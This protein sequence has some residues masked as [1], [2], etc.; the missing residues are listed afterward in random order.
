MAKDDLSIDAFGASFKGFLDKVTA[1]GPAEEP[2]LLCRFREHFGQA[3]TTLPVI[4]EKFPW[5]DR[6]NL[7]IAL[8]LYLGADG[9]A[10]DLVGI[11]GGQAAFTGVHIADL[12]ASHPMMQR[13]GAPGPGPVQYLNVALA[14]EQWLACVQCGVYFLRDGAE[15]LA[16]LVGGG[17]EMGFAG[18]EVRVEVMA[19]ERERGER[20]LAAIRTLMRQKNVYRGQVISLSMSPDRT[21]AVSFHALPQVA[22]DAIILPAGVLER[23]ERS[24]IRF[25]GHRDKLRAAGRH[26]KRGILLHG[27]PGTGKTLT[28]MHLAS[29]MPDRTVLIL[30]GRGQGLLEA[31]CSMARWLA[32][33]TVILEDVDLVAE[34]RTRRGADCNLPLLFEVMNEMD[35]LG[36]DADVLFLLTTNRPDILEPALASRPG[37]VDQ[38]I[39]IP[40]PDEVCRRRLL[41]FYGQGLRMQL[42][43]I[44]AVVNRTQGVSAAFVR[45]LLRKAALFAADEPGDIAVTDRH[46]EEAMRE[47][48]I[49]GGQLTRSLLGANKPQA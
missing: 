28:A 4:E 7:Q 29:R 40:L 39:E 22:R 2:E 36:D 17:R 44:E 45:E 5:S 42:A 32:P 30:T 11:T 21:I 47:L 41:E 19:A 35:G 24:T 23:V 1:S 20:F 15:R 33:S 31:S 12:L 26:L 37:R 3:P 27:P 13:N 43:D 38:A 9:R 49:D 6:P 46:I 16:V 18:R 48:V 8:D 25:A 14:G 34:D 10:F